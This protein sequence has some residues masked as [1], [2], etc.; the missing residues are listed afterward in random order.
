MLRRDFS[1]ALCFLVFAPLAAHSAANP[2]VRP[3]FWVAARGKSRV[4]LLGF[5][6]AKDN[7]WLTPTIEK[8]YRESSEV[9]METAAY[10]GGGPDDGE[11]AKRE[12]N[13]VIA[14]YG[15][16]PPGRSFFDDLEPRCRERTLT[17]I[18]NLGI[19]KEVLDPQRPWLGYYT[20]NGAFWA[21][22]PKTSFEIVYADAVLKKMAA[23]DKKAIQYELPTWESFARQMAA[24]S[25]TQQS[26]YVEW[27]LDH[28]DEHP[29][30][31]IDSDFTWLTGDP[32][33]PSLDRMRTQ[34]PELYQYI[35]VKRNAWWADKIGQLLNAP[36]TS[37]VLMGRLH[38]VGPDS[39]PAQLNRRGIEMASIT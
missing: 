39:I 29:N 11:V 26:E 22:K 4:Y 8:A 36:K 9:W 27:S 16:E 14:K 28:M 33:A 7:A 18:K 10:A 6:E 30:G 38:V 34:Y 3:P 15:L 1:L 12:F 24:M 25:A 13:D 17:F 32:S 35:Q 19:K 21:S 5:A 37:F 31:M 23:N 20:I 2:P